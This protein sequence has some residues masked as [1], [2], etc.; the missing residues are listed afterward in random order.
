MDVIEGS[1]DMLGYL[2]RGM[3]V[4]EESRALLGSPGWYMDIMEG[5][6][7]ILG[8][9]VRYRDVLEGSRGCWDVRGVNVRQGMVLCKAV[10]LGVLHRG[11]GLW[12]GAW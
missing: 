8:Y 7:D 4:S 11:T 1:R 3:D 6:R 2:I 10:V 5:Y 12:W 9:P